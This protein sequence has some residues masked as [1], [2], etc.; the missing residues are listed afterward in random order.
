M[1]I[2]E[3]P[4]AH[5]TPAQREELKRLTRAPRLAWPTVIL[6]LVLTVTFVV[7]DVLGVARLLPLWLCTLVNGTIGY[8]A[9]SVAHDSIHRSISSNVRLN[10]WIGRLAL[11]L[12]VPYATIGMFRWGHIQHH[13]FANGP[14]DPDQVFRGPWWQLPLRWMFIDGFYFIHLFRNL[15]KTSRP[16]LKNA[17]LA[18]AA[19]L[20]VIGVLLH[21]GYGLEVLMLWFIPSRLIMLSLGFSFFWLPHVPHDTAQ[22]DN[23]TR[24]TT[25]R[26]GYEGLMNVLLQYQNFHLIHHLYPGTPFYNNGKVWRL[27]EPELRKHDLAIQHGFDIHPR[28]HPGSTAPAAAGHPAQAE[29]RYA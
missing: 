10:D 17:L 12:A 2:P 24:A 11:P 18:A 25:V 14:R 16:H 3:I 8:V 29:V 20:T 21:Y 6:W 7:S 9:F 28:I 19:A 22:A 26:L 13:R 27:M 5:L 4:T 23:F 1:S 15:D